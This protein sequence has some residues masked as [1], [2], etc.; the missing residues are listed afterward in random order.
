MT[1]GP[2]MT[3]RVRLIAVDPPFSAEHPV[4][5]GLQDKRGGVDAVPATST[6]TFDTDIERTISAEAA[7][8]FRG[9]HVNGRKG[10]R[11]VYLSWGAANEAEPF[12]MFARAKIKLADIPTALLD[13]GPAGPDGAV[14]LDGVLQATNEKGQPASG[15][16]REPAIRWRRRGE[17]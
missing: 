5:F 15:T 8:D 12:V 17:A 9:E 4:R 13:E 3:I 10:D 2:S 7:P 6:T 14:E 16:I 1:S 11:F